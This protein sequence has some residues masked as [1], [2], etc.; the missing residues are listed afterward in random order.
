MCSIDS[1]RISTW[2]CTQKI[3][4]TPSEPKVMIYFW[5]VC[6]WLAIRSDTVTQL[7]L[8]SFSNFLTQTEKFTESLQ[9][10]SCIWPTSRHRSKLKP[11]FLRSWCSKRVC[12]AKSRWSDQNCYMKD[13]FLAECLLSGPRILESL[14][15]FTDRTF[16]MVVSV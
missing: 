5:T 10:Q 12:Y 9:L 16:N 4:L 13:I 3:I 11:C 14:R 7:A 2:F 1:S 15:L 6:W 8:L